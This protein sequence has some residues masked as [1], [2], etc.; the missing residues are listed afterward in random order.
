MNI[1]FGVDLIDRGDSNGN[2]VTSQGKETDHTGRW[3]VN[4]NI[5]EMGMRADSQTVARGYHSPALSFR[6]L[7]VEGR[8]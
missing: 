5:K 4:T 1:N 8:D 3:T 7:S 6:A 2:N